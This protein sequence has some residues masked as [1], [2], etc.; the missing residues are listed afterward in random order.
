MQSTPCKRCGAPLGSAHAS[1]AGP[2][3]QGMCTK[4][5]L[6]LG[7]EEDSHVVI[8]GAYEAPAP[9]PTPAELQ[10]LFPNYVIEDVLGQGGMGVV[11]RARQKGLDRPVAIKVLPAKVG[12][13]PAFAERF[14]REAQALA[15]LNHPNITN[16]YDF[17][18]AGEHHFLA[19]ELVEGVNLRQL[20]RTTKI[21]PK[22]ALSIVEQICDALQ[23][24]HDEG[25]VHRD[26][27][28]ENIL[29]DRKGR[30][31][32]TDFGLAKLL[33]RDDGATG[34]T[35][36]HQVMGTPHYMAPEQVER[37]TEVDH[38]ADIYSL[39]VVFYELLTGELPLGRF[40]PPSG[41]VQIDVK[42]DEVVL[43]ALAKEPA[44]RYQTAG[45][46]KTDVHGIREP[47]SGVRA[48]QA[49]ARGAAGSEGHGGF[50][51]NHR[52]RRLWPWILAA[53]IAGSLMLALLTLMLLLP[54]D[55]PQEQTGAAPDRGP[56]RTLA[57]KLAGLDLFARNDGAPGASA[58]FREA[59][60]L[61]AEVDA[62]VGA[63]LVRG[64]DRYRALLDAH[65]TTAVTSPTATH[66]ELAAFPVDRE[67][68]A[69]E[70]E[71]ELV[72]LLPA[73]AGDLVRD[74]DAVRTELFPQGVA[75]IAFDLKS[76]EDDFAWTMTTGG[77]TSAGAD[78]SL[79]WLVHRHWD[80]RFHD[81]HR[82][83]GPSALPAVSRVLA[84]L[85]RLR[86]D[87]VE[88]VPRRIDASSSGR[89]SVRVRLDVVARADDNV[90]ANEQLG[91]MLAR[92]RSGDG[93][94]AGGAGATAQLGSTRVEP[95]GR[96]IRASSIEIVFPARAP[97]LP[98][99]M[100]SGPNGRGG[101]GDISH[102][103]RSAAAESGVGE[104]AI[105]VR[106]IAT[107]DTFEDNQYKVALGVD[108]DGLPL[109]P[110]LRWAQRVEETVP[111]A[112]AGGLSL[113]AGAAGLW[114]AQAQIV[115]RRPR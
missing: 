103:L 20:E 68:L 53:G 41:K 30:L 74:R 55:V 32:I 15:T 75:P 17:G 100:S 105:S 78:V 19:M 102:A 14:T 38:R 96:G 71:R 65:T 31:K 92:L 91:E 42:L 45:A 43:R 12:R 88:V 56:S 44:L 3:L 77:V 16:V 25:V 28:P 2:A 114:D 115:A 1:E 27:K 46:V 59:G 106:Q 70:V 36:P 39:G 66:V 22:Q 61:T 58:A 29:I 109:E 84:E 13:D 107:G 47:G 62:A 48:T 99:P 23:Y 108:G 64:G 18:K 34:L 54:V 97:A 93:A 52:G 40:A 8:T 60:G 83:L 81:L 69:A 63:A 82:P 104:V 35:L 26:I 86:A 94:G 37:P 113:H 72:A 4:C 98:G 50:A 101:P 73:P 21:A 90:R 95:D 49:T 9:P 10:P 24:A 11:Y 87:G 33:G 89:M 80:Q 67:A 110:I 5:L 57:A 112:V 76:T 85:E 51:R 7:L 111:L 6:E 79:P